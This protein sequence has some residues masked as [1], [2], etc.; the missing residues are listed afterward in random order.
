MKELNYYLF[1]IAEI[2]LSTVGGTVTLTET[3][4][5]YNLEQVREE[6]KNKFGELK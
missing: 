3:G 1:K 2:I 5:I 4:T 6:L